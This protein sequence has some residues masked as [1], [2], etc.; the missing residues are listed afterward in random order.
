MILE[1]VIKFVGD[2]MDFHEATEPVANIVNT[3]EFDAS[4]KKREKVEFCQC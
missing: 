4:Y 2:F 1:A 3:N